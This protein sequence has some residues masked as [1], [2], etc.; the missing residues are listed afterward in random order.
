MELAI[1]ITNDLNYLE[2]VQSQ[3]TALLQQAGITTEKI[4]D[5]QLIVDEL[6]VN[7]INYAYPNQTDRPIYIQVSIY[8]DQWHMTFVDQGIPFD[9]LED[10][11]EPNLDRDDSECAEGGFGIFLVKQLAKEI[12]YAYR[13]DKNTLTVICDRW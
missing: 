5:A 6:L 2:K 8:P 4:W 13:D 12:K 3:I 11:T 7:I 1:T 9:P 10:K